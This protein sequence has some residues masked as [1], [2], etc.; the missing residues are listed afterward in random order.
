MILIDENKYA[1][2]ECI[3][4]HRSTSCRHYSRPLLQVRSKGRPNVY[5]NGNP[6]HRVAVF[7]QEVGD[8]CK[9]SPVI[10]LKSSAKQVI[11]V[12]T[13][14]IVGPYKEDNGGPYIRSDSFVNTSLCCNSMKSSGKGCSCNKK[15]NKS[16]ILKRWVKG[17]EQDKVSS[18]KM[19]LIMDKI[20]GGEMNWDNPLK[21]EGWDVIKQED[22]GRDAQLSEH[23]NDKHIKDIPL[24]EH[25]INGVSNGSVSTLPSVHGLQK[26]HCDPASF[27]PSYKP[28]AFPVPFQN[29]PLDSTLGW[30]KQLFDIVSVP[31]CSIPGSCGCG[32]D[33]KCDGCV[34]HGNAPG[35]PAKEGPTIATATL[36]DLYND[37]VFTTNTND[38]DSPNDECVCLDG[39]ECAN[40]EKHGIINGFKLDELFEKERGYSQSIQELNGQHSHSNQG[41]PRQGSLDISSQGLQSHNL[42]S[43]DLPTQS[44]P[45]QGLPTQS[46]SSQGLPTQSL[47][48]LPTQS[49][50]SLP[51]QSH[52]NHG[53]PNQNFS[54]QNLSQ[55]QSHLPA[56]H[57]DSMAKDSNN[58]SSL[59]LK[60][61][62]GVI[63]ARSLLAENQGL[64]SWNQSK[65]DSRWGTWD[66]NRPANGT[67]LQQNDD[68]YFADLQRLGH[69]EFQVNRIH[70]DPKHDVFSNNQPS[71][72]HSST[73]PVYSSNDKAHSYASPQTNEPVKSCC[74]KK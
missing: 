32:D 44:L 66:L 28:S 45:S 15:V 60:I 16:K 65:P 57:G 58:Q 38:I 24:N 12:V 10:V 1:C 23:I 54:G 68:R 7:A 41:L 34:Q 29:Q 62:G 59:S 18:A 39:C 5:A 9:K 74:S 52:P 50:P 70:Q 14:E 33:C 53:I 6:N 21:N 13:G 8:D 46:L 11:D 42:P 27:G 63:D 47:P 69:T 4:G 35:G 49:L 61:E 19:K 36:N 40:C 71:E 73:T 3:R 55:L 72:T 30:Q 64:L 67:I 56:N 48:N 31:S 17:K 43:Q 20:Y 51:T 2:V 26:S 22:D 37:V 25:L